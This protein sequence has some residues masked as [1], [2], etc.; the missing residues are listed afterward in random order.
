LAF[1]VLI[2]SALAGYFVYKKRGFHHNWNINIHFDG[3]KNSTVTEFEPNLK[4]CSIT[5]TSQAPSTSTM[6]PILTVEGVNYTEVVNNNFTAP[7]EHSK[8]SSPL[9][10]DATY[11]VPLN[12]E[13]NDDDDDENDKSRLI[14]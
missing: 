8:I 4:D 2:F 13:E 7:F 11:E 14:Q 6:P 3:N 5:P 12:G 10:N 1:L 9:S